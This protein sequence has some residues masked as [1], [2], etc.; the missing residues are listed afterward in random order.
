MGLILA[1]ALHNMGITPED[2]IL[3][4]LSGGADSVS[5]LL[6]LVELREKHCFGF[7]FA[8]HLNHGIRG[9][10]AAADAAFCEALCR[11]KGVPLTAANTDVPAYARETGMTLE[12]AARKKRRAFLEKAQ[13]ET[14]AAYLALAHNRNDQAE[15]LLM[16]LLRGSGL[17]GLR[18]MEPVNGS[19][20][21]P[22]LDVSREDIE[23]YLNGLGQPWRTDETNGDDRFTRN[24]IRHALLP[25]MKTFN[26]EAV[27]ALSRTA[28]LLNADE[29]YLNGL[30][31]ALLS[32]SACRDGWLRK[33]LSA[34][35]GPVQSRAIRRILLTLSEDVTGADIH[36]MTRLLSA[37]TG[38]VIELREGR[39][40]WVDAEALHAGD[41][42]ETVSFEIPFRYPGTVSLPV[43]GTL[44]ARQ[45]ETWRKPE[46]GSEAWLDE[47]KLPKNLVIRTRRPGDRFRPYGMTGDRLLSDWMTDKKIPRE[48]RYMPL[49]AAEQRVYYVAGYGVSNDAPITPS[50]E[51][52]LYLTYE[53]EKRL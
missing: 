42:P 52:I 20:I 43:G 9:E 51:K 49:L 35:P 37:Q 1:E 31:E 18:A 11:E 39:K 19:L 25:L 27:N 33:P 8:A 47:E 5:L 41:Y 45:A 7:L 21:R 38:T 10:H 3:V 4:G 48:A 22:L 15:T 16:H 26:P 12:Q 50:T 53:G 2:G 14:G 36:R 34:A 30:A 32:A 6:S 40:A 13:A 46:S 44:T 17:T 24:R 28:G 23:A 29:S